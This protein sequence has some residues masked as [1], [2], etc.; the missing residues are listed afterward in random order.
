[1][2]EDL[3][4]LRASDTDRERVAEILRDAVAEGRLA[5]EEFD[6]R[7]DAAYKARTYGELEP[8]TADLPVTGA[9]PAPLSLRKESGAPARWSER[10]VS[11]TD[12][13]AVGVGI[14]GG[15]QRKGRWTIGR[16]F[17]A[18]GVMGGGEIDLREANFAGPEI[19]ITCWALMGGVHIVVPPGVGLDVRGL[20]IMGGFDAREDGEPAE[21]GAPRVV[22]RGLALMGGVAVERKLPRAERR[23]LKEERRR[24]KE[25]GRKELD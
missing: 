21:P 10:I 20:G 22:V 8:L 5:M 19:V 3:P 17:T 2:T 1:M 11:G 16:H 6:E 13:S 15:F 14:M 4:E 25:D 23:R 7:L 12:G 24:L 9:A 18:V